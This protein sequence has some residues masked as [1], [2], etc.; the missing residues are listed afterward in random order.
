MNESVCNSKQKWNNNECRCECKELDAWGSCRN[1]CMW[2]PSTCNY[3][4]DKAC[5]TDENLDIKNCSCEKRLFGKLT[6]ACEDEILNTTE[7]SNNKKVACEKKMFY[8]HYFIG[9]YMLIIISY[10]IC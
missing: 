4:C 3:E 2:N 5:K 7:T 6:L 1:G 9:N 10:H 8:S